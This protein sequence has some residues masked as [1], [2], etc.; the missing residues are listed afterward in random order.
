MDLMDIQKFQRPK[1]FF[2]ELYEC[3]VKLDF[4]EK[5]P[6]YGS[7][8]VLF[9]TLCNNI[10]NK[11]QYFLARALPKVIIVQNWIFKF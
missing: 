3:K 7:W 9:G 11:K 1:L 2:F 8:W 6:N 4:L 10:L 5:K